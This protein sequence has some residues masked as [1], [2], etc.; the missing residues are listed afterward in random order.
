MGRW[1][2]AQDRLEARYREMKRRDLR[3]L[4]D[5]YVYIYRHPGSGATN[6]QR[7]CVRRIELIDH[8]LAEKE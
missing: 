7:F 4:R 8:L 5:E 1:R 2:I 6:L 3:V